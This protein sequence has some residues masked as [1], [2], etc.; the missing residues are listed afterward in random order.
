MLGLED[1]IIK[2]NFQECH[3]KDLIFGFLE[4]ILKL[5]IYIT[6][7]DMIN[8]TEIWTTNKLRKQMWSTWPKSEPQINCGMNLKTD[9][10]YDMSPNFQYILQMWTAKK[11]KKF[12]CLPFLQKL[13]R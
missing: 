13:K 2:R 5:K 6:Q 12:V 3:K 10:S 9:K 1:Y 4:W 11:K 8:V 7:A